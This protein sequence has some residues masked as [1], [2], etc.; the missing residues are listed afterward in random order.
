MASN[1]KRS[2][3]YISDPNRIEPLIL[4]SSSLPVTG[5]DCACTTKSAAINRFDPNDAGLDGLLENNRRWAEAV[6][7]EDPNFFKNIAL[8]QEPKIL[9]IGCSDSRVPA[10]QIVQLGPGEIFVHRNIANVVNHSDLNCLSVI[11]Y[12]VEVLKVQHIIVCGHYNCG[13]VTVAYNKQQFGLID[14]WL[15]NIKDV[16]RLHEEELKVLPTDLQRIHKLVEFNAINSAKNVC[17][18]TIVQNAWKNGQVLTVHAWAY[19][20]EDGRAKKLDWSVSDNK[21]LQDIYHH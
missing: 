4:T 3:V 20:I 19:D 5:D 13:G 2:D 9:W 10:N 21:A 1:S 17:H 15:R 11:Q 8:K 7:Q 12:A 18:S 14:N 6:V 16:Y